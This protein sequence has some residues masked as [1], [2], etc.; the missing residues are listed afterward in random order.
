MASSIHQLKLFSYF[1]FSCLFFLSKKTSLGLDLLFIPLVSA[2]TAPFS[3]LAG[4]SGSPDCLP[5]D[6]CHLYC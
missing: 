5:G 2:E 3:I 4:A 6:C 1:K